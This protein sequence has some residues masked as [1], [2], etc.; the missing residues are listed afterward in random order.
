M[1]SLMNFLSS[2]TGIYGMRRARCTMILLLFLLFLISTEVK[3]EAQTPYRSNVLIQTPALI[4]LQSSSPSGTL[5]RAP[6]PSTTSNRD[7]ECQRR[8][9]DWDRNRSAWSFFW[10][11]A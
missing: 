1:Y 5:Q 4:I 10:G 2:Q 9:A 8:H 11:F 6:T 7:I 3:I